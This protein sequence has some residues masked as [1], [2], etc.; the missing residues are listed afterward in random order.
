MQNS[1][2]RKVTE[3]TP[4]AIHAMERILGRSLGQDEAISISVYR[5]A[6]TGKARE[7]A[8]RQLLERV[9]KT[10]QRVHGVSEADIN[11]A[12]D[13]ASDHVRHHPE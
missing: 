6:P 8:S 9:A 5:P 13:E 1:A 4:D 3:L 11:A 12:I 2:L 7:E 10:S